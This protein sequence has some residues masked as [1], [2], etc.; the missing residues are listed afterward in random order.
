MRRLV[1]I[2]VWMGAGL[3][4]AG[5]LSVGTRFTIGTCH[6]SGQ[7]ISH[8]A[9]EAELSWPSIE[10]VEGAVSAE[11]HSWMAQNFSHWRFIDLGSQTESVDA[12][13]EATVED[14][15][16]GFGR[17]LMVVR[18]SASFLQN[19]VEIGRTVIYD[20]HHFKATVLQSAEIETDV[21]K[22]R[23]GHIF[24]TSRRQQVEDQVKQILQIGRAHV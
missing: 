21:L 4:Y 10:A 19:P 7:C 8:Y 17:T 16:Q 15:I 1:L 22:Q 12:L 14:E 5:G 24:N 6:Q 23:L 3:L 2:L 9:H 20:E 13:L 18:L 11:F